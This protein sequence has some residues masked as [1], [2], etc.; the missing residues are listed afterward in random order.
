MIA[1]LA[2]SAVGLVS[3]ATWEGFRE[4]AYDDGVGIQ[5]I[6]FGTTTGVKKG[7]RVTVEKALIALNDD[8]KGM[9]EE[10]RTCLGDDFFVSVNKSIKVIG[11]GPVG[12]GNNSGH[13]GLLIV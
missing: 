13:I 4:A 5:T 11:V 7:D 10:M 8:A 9:Q 2:L 3:I 12:R 6:G 1:G